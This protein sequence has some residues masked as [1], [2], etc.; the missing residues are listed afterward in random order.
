MN[1]RWD[2]LTSSKNIN[3]RQHLFPIA[4]QTQ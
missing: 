2:S 3:L 4:L 1:H